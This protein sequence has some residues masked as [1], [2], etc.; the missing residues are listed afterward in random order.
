MEQE[1]NQ[2]LSSL[3][4]NTADGDTQAFRRLY[5]QTSPQLYAI[6]LQ[7]MR[8]ESAADDVL[9]D[10]FVQVWHR[11]SDYHAER[12]TVMAWLTTI[13]R[14]R[15]IDM[16]RKQRNDLSLDQDTIDATAVQLDI[17]AKDADSSEPGG[18]M[19][20]AMADED[21]DYLAE[22]LSRLS[23]A[24]K[25]SVALAFFR[26]MTHQELS[27]CLA[28]PL[29]TIKS[30]L[31]RSLMRLKNCLAQLGYTDEIPPRTN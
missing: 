11:A 2:L 13:V 6:A 19:E 24:Q 5:D 21:A 4:R 30:R 8:A 3:L 1:K 10:A 14:Y 27:D 29:G 26:G 23:G 18:P 12:G 25:Q 28:M 9:Q 7:M 17:A 16:L 22:C 20:S 31:R 15:A